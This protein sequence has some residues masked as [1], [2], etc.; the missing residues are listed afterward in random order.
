MFICDKHLTVNSYQHDEYTL[1]HFN[2][3][4]QGSQIPNEVSK[5]TGNIKGWYGPKQYQPC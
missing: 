4:Y 5:D 1:M 3:T 2:F